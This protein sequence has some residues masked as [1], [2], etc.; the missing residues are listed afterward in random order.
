[1]GLAALGINCGRDVDTG[2]AVEILQRY[3][4]MTDLPLFVRLNAGTPNASGEY[5]KT[6]TDMAAQLP[7]LLKA[8]ATMIG[9]CCG[10]TP[11]TIEAFRNIV[12]KPPLARSVRKRVGT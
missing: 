2:A 10:T 12:S 5:L 7:R 9:G 1:M 6:P 3:R 8:G 4:T 11:Q